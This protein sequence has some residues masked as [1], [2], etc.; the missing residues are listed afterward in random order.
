MSRSLNAAH[1]H[2]YLVWQG[3]V[4]SL[5]S[6]IATVLAATAS[7]TEPPA[8]NGAYKIGVGDLL[9][10]EVYDEADLSGDYKVDSEGRIVF[11]MLGELSVAN[12]SERDVSEVLTRLLERDYLYHAQV[13]VAVKEHLS[14]KVELLGS[15]SKPGTYYLD[16]R[17]RLLDLLSRAGGIAAS[18]RC[19]LLAAIW[20]SLLHAGLCRRT[21]EL[22]MQRCFL[23]AVSLLPFPQ[24]LLAAELHEARHVGGR[25][26]IGFHGTTRNRALVGDRHDQH[27]NV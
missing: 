23:P 20:L 21:T 25:R 4:K 24:A 19:A 27:R 16:Q 14:K 11:P 26:S 8:Q 22:R 17:M 6:V 15:V 10:V 3:S 1:K 12:V 9:H 7:C 13:S 2:S 5:F 18:L